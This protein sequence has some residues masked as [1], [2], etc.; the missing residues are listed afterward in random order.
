MMQKSVS[1]ECQKLSAFDQVEGE[2]L[3]QDRHGRDLKESVMLGLAF[4]TSWVLENL[5]H[6]SCTLPDP[7]IFT[8]DIGIKRRGGTKCSFSENNVEVEWKTRS[9]SSESKVRQVV[10]N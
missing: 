2:F 3:M 10:D 8:F 5:H 4:Q 1:R 9:C 6:K 7:D